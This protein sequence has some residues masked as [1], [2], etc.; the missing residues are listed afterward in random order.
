MSILNK[1][2]KVDVLKLIL[3]VF[4][5]CGVILPI[6]V[7]LFQIDGNDFEKVFINDNFALLLG[8]SLLYTSITTIIVLVISLLSA[9]FLRQSNLK[10]K[11]LIVVLFSI[12]MLI[13][14][15]SHGLGIINLFGNNGLIDKI[16]N[17]SIEAYGLFGLIFASFLYSFPVAFLMFYDAMRYMDN[18]IFEAAETLGI[19][20]ITQFRRLV[21]PNLKIVIGSV[22]FSVFTMVFTDYGVPL[23]V[24][25]NFKTLPVYLY[26]EV[27]SRLNFSK[28]IIVAISLLIPAIIAF[29]YDFLIKKNNNSAISN[30]T[31]KQSLAFNIITFIACALIIFIIVLPI[32]SFT[33]MSFVQSFPNNMDFTLYHIEYVISYGT[34]DYLG[35]S[36]IIAILSAFFGTILAY[37]IAYLS[38]RIK[39]KASSILHFI[40]ITSMAIPGIVLGLSYIFVFKSTFIY[41]TILI[42]ILVNI[43]HFLSS[44]YLMAKNAL[45]QIDQNY[46]IVG[47]TLGISRFKIF[48][49]V[50]IPNSVLTMI[51]MFSY[52]FVNAMITISAVSFLASIFDMPLALLIPTFESQLS[53]E[54]AAIVSL[55][56]LLVNLLFKLL[57]NIIIK[58]LKRTKL[59]YA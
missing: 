5:F 15:I 43:V 39:S 6:L 37:F 12:P 44:P 13:P 55:I 24:A 57:L 38:S 18:K 4:L 2:P 58:I 19:N 26:Q 17:I 56:V 47:A 14:S 29:L 20:K 3:F 22:I 49:R 35:N 28:G 34:L 1:I 52:F 9:Y 45:M 51:E 21:L 32:I 7:M 30:D 11:S 27:I 40:T 8:N 36:L 41:G 50:I 16:F 10:H 42:L 59:R 46:E 31:I 23:A 54:A 25:G 53:Y 33:I 48:L